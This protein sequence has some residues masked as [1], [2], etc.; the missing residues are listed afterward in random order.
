MKNIL[1][2]SASALMLSLGSLAA[3]A[4]TLGDGERAVITESPATET[5]TK[6]EGS[7]QVGETKPD[8]DADVTKSPSTEMVTTDSVADGDTDR[9]Q[10]RIKEPLE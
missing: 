5:V 1:T 4:D 3:H 9:I 8:G 6:G 10:K 2:I 7:T